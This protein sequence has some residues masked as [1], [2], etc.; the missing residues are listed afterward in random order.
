MPLHPY[1]HIQ[2]YKN[3]HHILRLDYNYMLKNLYIHLAI[4][5]NHHHK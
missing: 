5:K 2:Y 3:H 4:Y 1:S